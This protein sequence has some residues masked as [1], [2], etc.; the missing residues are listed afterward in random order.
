MNRLRIYRISDKYIRFLQSRDQKVQFNKDHR[1]PYLGVVLLVG[2]YKYFVPMESP[3]PNH[4]N[5][6]NGKHL[7]RIDNG[8]LGIL[9]FNNM[10][11]VP[12]AVVEEVDIEHEPD[13]NYKNLLQRQ[14]SACNKEKSVIFSKAADTYYSVVNKKN[15]F[16]LGISCDFRA[17]E[18]ASGEY[19]PNRKPRKPKSKA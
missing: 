10:I 2:G 4:V 1:R 17:L 12:D 6:K 7:Y 18:R 5:M 3:K 19:D 13:E 14:A 9:G 8:K 16:L 15:K 11:P